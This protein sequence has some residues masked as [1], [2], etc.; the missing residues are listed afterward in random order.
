MIEKVFKEF[1]EDCGCP[2]EICCK[3]KKPVI[4]VEEVLKEINKRIEFYA[5]ET[6]KLVKENDLYWSYVGRWHEMIEFKEYLK[7]QVSKK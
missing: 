6:T 5:N 1:C 7:N 4:L 3:P 2:L